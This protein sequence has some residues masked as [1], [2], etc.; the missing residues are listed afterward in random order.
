[1]V[2]ILREGYRIPFIAKPPS[3]ATSPNNPSGYADR[4]KNEI[5]RQEIHTLLRKRAIE[6]VENPGPGYYSRVFLRPK[7][8]GGWRPILDLKALN[9]FIACPKFK[10]ETPKT[11]KLGLRKGH[12]AFSVDLQ[13]AFFHVP[14]HRKSRRFLRLTFEGRT[15]QYRVLPFGLKPSPYIFTKVV[16]ELKAMIH[17]EALQL[18]MFLDD[19]L[20]QTPTQ[21]EGISQVQEITSLCESL[22]L[23][24]NKEKSE[25]VPKQQFDF[26]GM[27][28]D[29][30]SFMVSCTETNILH[31]DELV[32]KML[33]KTDWPA[34]DWLSIIGV[35]QSQCPM[36]RYGSIFLRPLQLQLA[37]VWSQSRD[38]PS[39][40]VPLTPETRLALRWWLD[41]AHL[42]EGTPIHALEPNVH[43]FTD[44][45]TVGWGGHVGEQKFAGTWSLEERKLHINVLELRALKLVLQMCNPPV[46]SVILAS[47]DNSTVVAYVNRLG[48]TRSW[49]LWEETKDMFQLVMQKKWTITARHIAGVLNVLADRL[50][51]QG[52]ILPTEWSLHQEAANL[53]FV[54]W[55]TAL[56]DL[57]ATRDNKKCPTFVSPYPD[58]Q[59]V[60]TDALSISWEGI[61]GYA[62][63]PQAILNKVLQKL[64]QTRSL[65]LILVTPLWPKQA[66]YPELVKLATE[67][68]VPLPKWKHLLKQPQG[69]LYHQELDSLNLQGWLVDK[70]S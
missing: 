30:R 37:K 61:S 17:K 33:R 22:G 54:K 56:V 23:L 11:I 31:I 1:V 40:R 43:T 69:N 12:W 27:H 65:R 59:A 26:I 4:E 21:E 35:L 57:F 58:P 20:G 50:S 8:T 19:W 67:G 9:P 3:L 41:A 45:S 46:G 53:L 32:S 5:I 42:T 52:Q 48:G 14:V 6:V 36:T 38:P 60:G 28:F 70:K 34:I 49:S 55:G 7:K 18:F 16:G 47:T 39:N 2:G 64:A 68:P 10:Q 63:P 25:L 66:W 29:L 62:Y 15:Y 13:D 44:A 24:I 51:R